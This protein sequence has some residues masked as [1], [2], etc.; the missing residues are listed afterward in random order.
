MMSNADVT[1]EGVEFLILTSPVT[2]NRNNFSVKVT[3]NKFL[4]FV[5]TNS[6]LLESNNATIS[7]NIGHPDA[8][9]LEL[10][11]IMCERE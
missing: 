7:A 9:P 1:K 11:L 8:V 10:H 5:D 3:F 4:K 6:T 2:L